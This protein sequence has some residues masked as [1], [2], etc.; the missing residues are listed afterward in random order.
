MIGKEKVFW[1]TYDF[2]KKKGIKRIKG[3]QF[4]YILPLN[5][6][7]KKIFKNSTVTWGK[8]YPK[9]KDLQWKEMVSQGKYEFINGEPKFNLDVVEY[10]SKNV[11][12][13]KK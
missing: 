9:D 8:E 5:K 3:K 13:G 1:L 2:M 7:A 6:K 10:N 12:G 4:R 11:Y